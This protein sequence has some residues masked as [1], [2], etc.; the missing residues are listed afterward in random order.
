MDLLV[1]AAEHVGGA[2]GPTSQ[3]DLL[4]ARQMQAMSFVVHIPL[5]CFGITFPTMVLFA[6]G[7][8]GMI[9]LVPSLYLLYSF[10]LRGRL[11]E[12]SSHWTSASDH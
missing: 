10:V 7:P 6:E 3:P 9:L 11:D 4:A 8:V 2:L 1:V 12:D 5:V